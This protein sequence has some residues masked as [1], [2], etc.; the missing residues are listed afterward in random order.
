MKQD[1]NG[2]VIEESDLIHVITN[3]NEGVYVIQRDEDD[4]LKGV[5]LDTIS[6]GVICPTGTTIE[7][8]EFDSSQVE[9]VDIETVKKYFGVD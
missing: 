8:S 4:T 1:K 7:F 2:Y 6:G 9:I 5:S 3:S